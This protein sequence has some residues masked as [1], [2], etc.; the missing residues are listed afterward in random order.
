MGG[1]R[2]GLRCPAT[3]VC[4]VEL[5]GPACGMHSRGGLARGSQAYK[6]KVRKNL[7]RHRDIHKA[8]QAAAKKQMKEE[9]LRAEEEQDAIIL[10]ALFGA[11]E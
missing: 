9:L 3:A 4:R 8:E 1:R 7:Q 11:Y 10:D 5:W 2:R 6:E